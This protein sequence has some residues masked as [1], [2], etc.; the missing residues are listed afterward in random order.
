MKTVPMERSAPLTRVSHS[1]NALT[2]LIVQRTSPVKQVVVSLTASVSKMSIAHRF[3]SVSPIIV[4]RGDAERVNSVRSAL[5]ALRGSVNLLQS[6]ERTPIVPLEHVVSASA[7][8]LPVI[9][10]LMST[11]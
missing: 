9:V 10:A 7:V 6:A 11:A 2:I 3:L 5:S 1:L 4:L 8:Y